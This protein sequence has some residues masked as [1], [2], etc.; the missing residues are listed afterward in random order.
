MLKS[1]CLAPMGKH[2]QFGTC[3]ICREVRPLSFEHVP[4]RSAFNDR[5]TISQKVRSLLG[6]EPDG[7]FSKKGPISQKG[8]GAYTL[9]ERCNNDT[10]RWYASAYVEWAYQGVHLIQ[11]AS[12]APSLYHLFHLF[13]LRVIKQIFCMFFSANPSGLGKRHEDLAR[14][15]LNK[16]FRFDDPPLRVFA[17]FNAGAVSRQSA[18]S[19][20]FDSASGGSYLFSEIAFPPFGYILSIDGK[21]PDKRLVDIS[22]FCRYS[23]N[24]WTDVALRLPVFPIYTWF[25]ADFRSRD[26]VLKDHR[27]QSQ[28][29]RPA[30]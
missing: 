22:Y 18:F 14:F 11:H 6:T 21:S 20:I 3:H 26:E 28:R 16:G 13:P 10:G 5:P 4:P 29:S 8:V 19:G 15:V 9:C 24:Q 17:Y 12:E 23:Y 30:D 7:W 25:P 2:T 1:G 27:E